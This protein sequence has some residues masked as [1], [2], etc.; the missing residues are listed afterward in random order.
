[1]EV[2]DNVYTME[3]LEAVLRKDHTTFESIELDFDSMWSEQAG[4]W[5]Y[6]RKIS[7][8]IHNLRRTLWFTT[9]KGHLQSATY[10]SGGV[11]INISIDQFTF[12][13]PDDWEIR[14]WM[15]QMAS[16]LMP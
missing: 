3:R 16:E 12:G 7:V 6:T 9:C 5:I 2:L 11:D 4:A 1:M 15:G 14:K 8:A 10:S 13:A